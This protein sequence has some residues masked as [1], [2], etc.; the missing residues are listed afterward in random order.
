[1]H[2]DEFV[3]GVNEFEKSN[4]FG[5]YVYFKT[6]ERLQ[7][8]CSE[9]NLSDVRDVIRMFLLQWGQMGRAIN[10]EGTDW[11]GLYRM[12]KQKCDVFARLSS[13]LVDILTFGSTNEE[14]IEDLYDSLLVRNIGSTSVSKVL[15]VLNP[16][17]FV[18]W[19]DNIRTNEKLRYR[20]Y[21]KVQDV[22]VDSGRGYLEFLTAAKEEVTEALKEKAGPSI[23][24]SV[25]DQIIQNRL[26]L[27]DGR[28]EPVYANKKTL[29][30][31]I[32]EY[33]WNKAWS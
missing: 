29:A 15:H 19:D 23:L 7:K 24:T 30:K 17:L 12:I 13:P 25:V 8:E 4:W 26:E 16:R 2:Y 21:G 3:D 18:P 22:F 31:L 32:D 33:N 9:I 28:L 10:R 14:D 5:E 27:K 1:M 6:V 11:D 20:L